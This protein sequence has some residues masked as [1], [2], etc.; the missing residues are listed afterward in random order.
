MHVFAHPIRYVGGASYHLPIPLSTMSPS[1]TAAGEPQFDLTFF[2]TYPDRLSKAK[3]FISWAI[4]SLL[5]FHFQRASSSPP[6]VIERRVNFLGYR[7]PSRVE[8][9]SP[10]HRTP[11]ESLAIESLGAPKSHPPRHRTPD[12]FLA[13]ESLLIV[14][15]RCASSSRPVPLNLMWPSK[16]FFHSTLRRALSSHLPV[17]R[18]Q[19][20]CIVSQSFPMRRS[21]AGFQAIF[22]LIAR[23]ASILVPV[24]ASTRF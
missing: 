19:G 4:E 18:F 13:I 9:A 5:L 15:F 11:G 22:L 10:C 23:R 2:T 20:Y 7:K 21:S 6:R 3:I 16:A 1:A 14:L 12:G 8:S 17:P 24:P